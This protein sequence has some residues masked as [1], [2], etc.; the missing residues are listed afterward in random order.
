MNDKE[1]KAHKSHAGTL[2]LITLIVGAIVFYWIYEAIMAQIRSRDTRE[3]V[4][5]LLCIPGF[6]YFLAWGPLQDWY[7]SKLCELSERAKPSSLE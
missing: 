3:T 7:L 6:F 1:L 5:M 2:A 4:S